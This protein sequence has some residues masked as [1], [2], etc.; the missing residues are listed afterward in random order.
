MTSKVQY[1]EATE[2]RP[3]KSGSSTTHFAEKGNLIALLI[4]RDSASLINRDCD[5]QRPQIKELYTSYFSV[6]SEQPN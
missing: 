3:A 4:N 5:I 2:K 6:F 1:D